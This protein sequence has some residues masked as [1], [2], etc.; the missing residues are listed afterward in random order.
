MS[1]ATARAHPNIALV[2]YWGKRDERLILPHQSSLSVTLGPL[3]VT[4]RVEFTG[5]AGADQ[6]E[7]NGREAAG[8][9]RTRVTEIL[10]VI[11]REARVKGAA[12]VTSSGDFPAAAG[13]ASSAAAF[14]AL[15][16]AGRA[17][18][19]LPRDTKA[20]SILA[21][22]GSG[23]AARSVQGGFVRWNRGRRSDGRDSFAEQVFTAAHWPE[24]RLL[25]A[26]VSREEQEV[27]SRDGM[28][29]AVK[30]SPYYAA[31]ARDA[32]RE[33]KEILRP[34]KRRDLEAVGSIAERN[35]W[36]MHATSLAANPPLCYLRPGTLAIIEAARLARQKGVH[37][38]FT[39]DAGPNPVLLTTAADEK[40]VTQLA[41]AHGATS[42]VPCVPGGDAQL[43]QA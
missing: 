33:V 39:L 18:A 27:T 28:K 12:R 29:N 11:K 35:A 15:A 7:I 10:K 31:W 21:R 43:I 6:V 4:T 34:L 22:L 16:V 14:A 8:T 40:A 36:R 17:A 32:E 3:S 9:E 5:A 38:W 24:L 30:T 37:A 25:V 26:M 42:V 41:L 13:L 1:H 23:S 2:K 20:E 19:G